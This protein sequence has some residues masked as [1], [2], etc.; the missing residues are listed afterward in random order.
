MRNIISMGYTLAIVAALI[1]VPLVT[2][3]GYRQW[4]AVIFYAV[5]ACAAIAGAIVHYMQ[6]RTT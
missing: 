5:A 6:H 3:H 4:W 2:L 1:W